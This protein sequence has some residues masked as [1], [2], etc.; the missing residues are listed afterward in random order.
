MTASHP[1]RELF[2]RFADGALSADER[3]QVVEHLIAGCKPCRELAE[4]YWPSSVSAAP[5]PAPKL[6]DRVLARLQEREA[7]ATRER[8]EAEDL[9]AAI[10]PD[11]PARRHTQVVNRRRYHTYAFCRRLQDQSIT[12]IFADP[13]DALALAELSLAVAELVPVEDAT[14]A[15]LAD[16]KARS[17][18]RIANVRRVLADFSGAEAAFGEAR[19]WLSRG[20]AD[21]IEEAELLE[22]EASLRGS[23]RRFAEAEVGLQRALRLQRR[24]GDRHAEGKVL[25]VLAVTKNSSGDAPQAIDLLRQALALI[26][27]SRDPRLMINARHNLAAFLA[28]V[29][30][31]EE[32]LQQV[33]VLR[34]LYDP[35]R[36]RVSLVRLQYLESRA[37]FALGD[38]STAL[39]GF[40]EVQRQFVDLGMPLEVALASLEMATIQL[41]TGALDAAQRLATETLAICRGLGIEREALGALLVIEEA[42]QRKALTHELLN[43]VRSYLQQA[44]Q[45]PGLKFR[46]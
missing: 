11:S 19:M 4:R 9:L 32:A 33:A 16:L 36:D 18:A 34:T 44:R 37:R 23:Q 26:D 17:W 7:R 22:L 8:E 3:R 30:Q 2:E 46:G 25:V 14:P 29:G 5:A 1:S 42:A 31:P 12:R 40:A 13:R 21:P 38:P 6:S 43:E 35:T 10:L 41:E 39:A 28:N 15:L 24:I 20:T 27:P 45:N